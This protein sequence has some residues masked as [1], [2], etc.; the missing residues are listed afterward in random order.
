MKPKKICLC[1]P[2][3]VFR[4]AFI[5]KPALIY[6]PQYAIVDQLVGSH[7]LDSLAASRWPAPSDRRKVVPLHTRQTVFERPQLV[8]FSGAPQ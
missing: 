3:S 8:Q 1:S 7:F 5:N 2:H 6:F 4:H